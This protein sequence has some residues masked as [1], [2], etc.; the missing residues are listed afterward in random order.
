MSNRIYSV[1]VITLTKDNNYELVKTLNSINK[2][3]FEGFIEL[4]IIDGSNIENFLINELFIKKKFFLLN[5]KITII[6]LN[7]T[8]ENVFGIYP[9]MN[10]GIRKANGGNLIFM[11]SGDEFYNNHS[12]SNLYKGINSLNKRSSFCFGQAEIKTKLGISWRIPGNQV[13]NINSWLKIMQPNH[14]SIIVSRFLAKNNYFKEDCYI[15]S[16]AVW[17]KDILKSSEAFRFINA[18]VSKF[19]IGGVSSSKPTL[20]Q[21]KIQLKNKYLSNLKKFI[22]ILKFLIPTWSYD[23]FVYVQKLK[24]GIIENIILKLI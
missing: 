10:Y 17:K 22:I 2:Q 11:N 16:D 15:V 23:Y 5:K 9:S 13:K 12:I 7:A 8:K 14:Q 6:H 19:Y 3:A 21:V 1:T 4:L 18:P 20:K 24:I